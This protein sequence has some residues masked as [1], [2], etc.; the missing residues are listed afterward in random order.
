M[1]VIWNL[2]KSKMTKLTDHV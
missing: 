2:L 1:K